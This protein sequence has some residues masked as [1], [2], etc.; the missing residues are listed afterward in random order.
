MSG[1]REKQAR[2]M[3]TVISIE[4]RRGAREFARVVART[5]EQQELKNLRRRQLVRKIYGYAGV[6]LLALALVTFIGWLVSP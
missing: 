2:R 4:A 5:I 1:K 6:A 3:G